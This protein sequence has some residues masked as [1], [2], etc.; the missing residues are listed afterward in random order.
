MPARRWAQTTCWSCSRG[1]L[2]RGSRVG[3]WAGPATLRVRAPH[4]PPSLA[5]PPTHPPGFAAH[6]KE[7]TSTAKYFAMGPGSGLADLR[8]QNASAA[9]KFGLRQWN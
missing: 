3:G 7:H 4:R 6:D 9:S 2:V 5:P 8:G 1:G